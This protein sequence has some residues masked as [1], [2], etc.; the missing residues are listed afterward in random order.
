MRDVILPFNTG[1]LQRLIELSNETHMASRTLAESS[2]FSEPKNVLLLYR[3]A[4][5]SRD[6]SDFRGCNRRREKP[7]RLLFF[8]VFVA[9]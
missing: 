1:R 6:S 8:Q 2:R 5:N 7:T 9:K 4:A 3:Q